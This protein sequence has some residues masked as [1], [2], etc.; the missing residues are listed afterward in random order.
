LRRDTGGIAARLPVVVEAGG[1]ADLAIG[2]VQLRAVVSHGDQSSG[3]DR[4]RVGPERQ[5][6]GHVRARADAARDDELDSTVET[7]LGERVHGEADRGQCGNPD[8]LD[9]DILRGCRPTLHPVHDDRVRA[10][11]HGQLDV[12]VRPRRADLD[13]DRLLPVG[14]LAQLADLDLEVVGAGPVRVPARAALVDSLRQVAHLGDP[15]GDLVPEQHAAPA[16]LRPLA[17]DDL[18][19][20]AAAQ[21][22]RIHAV[23]G[24]ENL[25]EENARVLALLGRHAA[26]A[27]RRRGPD[28]G[29]APPERLF[30]GRREGAEAHAGDRDRNLELERLPCE[31]GPER[32]VRVAALAVALERIARD[33]RAEEEEVVEVRDA[34]LR[35]EA[36]DVVDALARGALDL[37]DD[38]AVEEVRLAQVPRV[39]LLSHQYAEALSTWKA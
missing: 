34:A 2:V 1:A 13:E 15:V 36:A 10:R 29:R 17:D 21:V 14:D 33:A 3:A 23:A 31:A 18:D 12:V 24:G 9:E 26:V 22:V 19:R 28:L 30:R 11:L 38:R 6:L 5:R 25:V 16:G 27:G 37:G 8:M 39:L 4:D 20:V 32:D 35:P 7:E